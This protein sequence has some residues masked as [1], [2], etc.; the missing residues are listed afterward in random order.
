[1]K[2]IVSVLFCS[3]FLI[4]CSVPQSQKTQKSPQTPVVAK[5]ESVTVNG[6]I[7]TLEPS[8]INFKMIE[9]HGNKN[10]SAT[11]HGKGPYGF[12]VYGYGFGFP[13][14][15][16]IPD[17]SSGGVFDDFKL[18]FYFNDS[19]LHADGDKPHT[20]SGYIPIHVY[21]GSENGFDT[22][23]LKLKINLTVY[24]SYSFFIPTNYA[25]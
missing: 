8:V 4:S 6:A 13:T 23:Y 15:G 25:N 7:Y 12:S 24:P 16:I 3:L 22:N 20:Y 9:T 10:F 19:V 14:Y 5:L 21:Q 11:I 17:T 1:M 2:S 18:K